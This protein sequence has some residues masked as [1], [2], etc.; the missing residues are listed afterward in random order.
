[1]TMPRTTVLYDDAR[2]NL[3]D[4]SRPRP[5]R[6]YT[7]EPEDPAPTIIVSHGTGGSGGDMDWMVRPLFDA[8]FRV[9]ALD[10]HGNNFVDG[11]EPEGFIHVWERPLDIKFVL[12]TFAGDGPVGI[13]GFSLGA[14]TAAAVVGARLNSEILQGLWSGEIPLP[15]IPEFPDVMDALR[16]KYTDADWQRLT[17]GAGDDFTDPRIQAV[18]M[19]APGVGRFVTPDSLAAITVPVDIH[20]G[21][22]DTINP[23][24]ADTV[25]YLDHIPTATGHCV[26]SDV[27][28][29]DFFGSSPASAKVG[30]DAAAFFNQQCR[31]LA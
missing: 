1:M 24:D 17:S 2:R 31:S 3:R 8:G 29:D 28:H 16:A 14:Y 22:A 10:H 25:P 7:W 13:A 27:V 20:W 18:F 26:G 19:V 5:I 9:V 30:S 4:S 23:Y 6:I 15:E 21:G 11:Y 12:D